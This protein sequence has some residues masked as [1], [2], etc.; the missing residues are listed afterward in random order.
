[1]NK[2]IN[3]F[4]ELIKRLKS[5]DRGRALLF[6]GCYLIFFIILFILISTSS[7]VSMNLSDFEEGNNIKFNVDNIKNNNYSYKYI[8]SVDDNDYVF[9][10]TRYKDYELYSYRNENY[11]RNYD[12]DTIFKNNNNLWVKSDNPNDLDY[13]TNIDN[14]IEIT[15]NATYIS[16]TDYK[17]G[18]MTYNYEI[19]TTTLDK[20]INDLDIDLDDKP[21]ELFFSTDEDE[22]VNYIKF[23]LDSYG[24]YK[25]LCDKKLSIELDYDDFNDIEEIKN[26][27]NE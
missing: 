16:K 27:I 9:S 8:I 23:E 7:K 2:K 18:K 6:F 22:N 15:N 17:S 11:F 24:K 4:K 5:T 25:K 3:D 14:I 1:M 10:G 19:S 26:P 20:I 13:F 21:N 12:N